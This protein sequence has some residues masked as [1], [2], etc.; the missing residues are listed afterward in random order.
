MECVNAIRFLAAFK[1]GD[2]GVVDLD[3][4]RVILASCTCL[5]KGFVWFLGLFVGF[6]LLVG[7]EERAWPIF[8]SVRGMCHHGL[9]FIRELSCFCVWCSARHHVT[10]DTLCG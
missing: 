3:G 2:V 5:F 10:F 1:S 7:N 4:I 8:R 9:T 6:G